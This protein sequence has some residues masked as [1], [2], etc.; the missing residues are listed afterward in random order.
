[1]TFSE[2]VRNKAII[3]SNNELAWKRRDVGEAIT[4]LI[5]N[6]YAILGGDVWAI[7]SRQKGHTPLSHI[8][9]REIAVGIIKGQDGRDYV[10]DWH[11]DKV[12]SESWADYVKR[13]GD[14]T[15]AAIE[16]L[17]AESVVDDEFKS[18]IYYN[19]VYVDERQFAALH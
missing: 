3:S 2:S 16:K 15:F 13:T 9:S 6:G 12:Q 4:E 1:M 7:T 11:S 18:N 19:L 10:F 17:N 8:N 5:D 14:E